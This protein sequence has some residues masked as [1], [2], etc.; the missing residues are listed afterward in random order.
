M[1]GRVER[2]DAAGAAGEPTPAVAARDERRSQRRRVDPCHG[3]QVRD[4]GPAV[5]VERH[6][7]DDLRP[8]RAPAE[9]RL[10]GPVD[11]E[12]RLRRL[13]RGREERRLVV[14]H[15]FPVAVQV[16]P[17]DRGEVEQPEHLRHLVALVH[18]VRVGRQERGQRV[19]LVRALA[20]LVQLPAELGQHQR[21]VLLVDV[22]HDVAVVARRRGPLP[23]DVD[24]VEDARRRALAAVRIAVHLGQVAL[25]EHV[26]A[27]RHEGAPGLL[28][29]RRV[30]EVFRERPPADRYLRPQV[31]VLLLELLEL[32][33]VAGEGLAGFVGAAVGALRGGERPLVVVERVAAARLVVLEAAAVG[34]DVRER[35]VEHGHV[36]GLAVGHQVLDQ[37]VARVAGRP[38]RE[39]ADLLVPRVTVRARV[40]RRGQQ[41]AAGERAGSDE[42]ERRP[43]AHCLS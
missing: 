2:E 12:V 20:V 15:Q 40:R 8:R 3:I 18:L 24:A 34:V 42:G 29:Q 11:R 6:A 43:S 39:V 9:E 31:G 19:V 38:V 21:E 4:A 22:A 35:V 7:H 23:V 25:D 13:T 28:G 14:G 30:G 33:E 17:L 27:G 26:D 32:V 41:D 1:G 5:P 10:H 37:E 36:A 16:V